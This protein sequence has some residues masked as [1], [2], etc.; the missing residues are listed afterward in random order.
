MGEI[1][2]RCQDRTQ[3]R[4]GAGHAK[5]MAREGRECKI[6]ETT[7]ESE[8][9]GFLNVTRCV[10]LS[11]TSYIWDRRVRT[12]ADFVHIRAALIETL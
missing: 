7:D 5:E 11:D 1:R 8:A 4:N 3:D 6:E 10:G 9:I 12:A 2:I